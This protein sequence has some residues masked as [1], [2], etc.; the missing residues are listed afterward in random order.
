[1]N[2]TMR[3]IVFILFV[4]PGFIFFSCNGAQK[5][6][7]DKSNETICKCCNEDSVLTMLLELPEVKELAKRIE[8]QTNGNR[9]VS[10]MVDF[11]EATSKYNITM[12]LN[13]E[14]RFETSFVFEV[15]KN[16]CEVKVSDVV[17]GEMLP[18]KE[19]Q[20]RYKQFKDSA[21]SE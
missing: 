17:T 14:E 19:W 4:L 15:D 11:D 8:V 7:I 5:G 1:M 20:E 16:T 12:G 10:S 18:L 2:V 6:G 9:G 13:G 21:K 3:K